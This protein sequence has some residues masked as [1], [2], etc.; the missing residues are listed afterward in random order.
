MRYSIA[1]SFILL[2]VLLSAPAIA[3]GLGKAGETAF[4]EWAVGQ[5]S[6]LDRDW[7]RMAGTTPVG[8]AGIRSSIFTGSKGTFGRSNT[9]HMTGKNGGCD[10]KSNISTGGFIHK[11]ITAEFLPGVTRERS[12]ATRGT[13][14]LEHPARAQLSGKRRPPFNAMNF[15]RNL[16]TGL[17]GAE[18]HHPAMGTRISTSGRR[19]SASSI[20]YLG[21][22]RTRR[23]R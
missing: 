1:T 21:S 9:I 7:H 8:E 4:S 22:S 10:W 5:S 18:R 14:M 2:A 19:S 16:S 6:A 13:G 11:G 3:G 20:N 23:H 17:R 12:G 15:D